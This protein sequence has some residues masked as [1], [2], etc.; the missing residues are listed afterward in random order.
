MF[1]E[2]LQRSIDVYALRRESPESEWVLLN[3]RPTQGWKN[4]SR[5]EYLKNGRSEMLQA[6][7][8]AEILKLTGMIGKPIDSV[9][10]VEQNSNLFDLK[11][12]DD[13]TPAGM[14]P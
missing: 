1:G 10:E 6:V 8:H 2:G 13:Q 14:R 5:E 9:E 7:S 12:E 11:P 3:D 4:M